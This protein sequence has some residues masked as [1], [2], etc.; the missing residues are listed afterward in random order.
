MKNILFI[1]PSISHGGAEKQLAILAKKLNDNGFNSYILSLKNQKN[2]TI[3]PDF[4]D[5]N[6]IKTKIKY[7]FSWLDFFH[8]KNIV[9]NINPDIIQGWMYSGNIVASFLTIGD[10]KKKYFTLFVPQIW[11]LKGMG[12]KFF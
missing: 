3:L 10:N 7:K 12:D 4:K 9:N 8:L 1:T 11:I 6:V 2:E 5:L